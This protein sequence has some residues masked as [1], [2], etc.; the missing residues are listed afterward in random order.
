MSSREPFIPFYRK[1]QLVYEA[2]NNPEEYERWS[3]EINER[4]LRLKEGQPTIG[5]KLRA[6]RAAEASGTAIEDEAA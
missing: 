6:M 5:E 3:A 1:D 4:Y 2:L